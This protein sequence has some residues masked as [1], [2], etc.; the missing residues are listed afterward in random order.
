MKKPMALLAA[1]LLVAAGH[2]ARPGVAGAQASKIIVVSGRLGWPHSMPFFATEL[3]LWQKYG[4]NPTRGG[5]LTSVADRVDDLGRRVKKG[6]LLGAIIDS[7]TLEI[8]KELR[9]PCDGILF[10]SR[11][12]GVVEAGAKGF[13]IA[14]DAGLA[15]LP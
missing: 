10:F 7:Y 14:D 5:Y 8:T 2:G 15:P 12:S 4:F 13:A 11:M 9:A 1:L 3:G 6:E